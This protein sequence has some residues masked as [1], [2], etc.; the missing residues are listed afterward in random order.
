MCDKVLTLSVSRFM[1]TTYKSNY[2]EITCKRRGAMTSNN[3]VKKQ[4]QR[5]GSDF[6]FWGRSEAK[7]LPSILFQDETLVHA[8]NGRYE[9][10]FALFCATDQR[11]LLL[12]KKPLIL[13][14]EDM[15]YEMI[16]EVDYTERIFDATL[17]LHT[18]GRT[19]RFT[20]FRV[21]R[22]RQLTSFIQEK[23][24]YLRH[25][26]DHEQQPHYARM[27]HAARQDE[28]YDT[29]QQPAYQDQHTSYNQTKPYRTMSLNARRRVPKFTPPIES[30]K[31]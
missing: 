21:N 29:N 6:Q 9:K 30:H 27:L 28:G 23:V 15:R 10:G 25:A 22:L 26:S 24:S 4:L 17:T 18:P 2:T 11:L 14:M 7:Q 31:T 1:V 16:S 12:D 13:C 8:L 20:T 19:L 3:A 5:I